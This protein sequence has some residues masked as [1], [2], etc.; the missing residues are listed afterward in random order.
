LDPVYD[1]L[2]I[3]RDRVEEVLGV[4]T[5][6]ASDPEVEARNEDVLRKFF[7]K[8]R[9]RADVYLALDPTRNISQVAQ[10]LG[11]K[12]QN[13][14]SEIRALREANLILPQ[15]VGGRGDVWVRNPTL[16][17]VLRLSQKVRTWNSV[18][19]KRPETGA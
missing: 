6:I 2:R 9:R 17:R 8:G 19:P 13:V 15:L 3:V 10:T 1:E 18:G 12:R 16:E 11:M 5:Y 4:L 7:G 14:S